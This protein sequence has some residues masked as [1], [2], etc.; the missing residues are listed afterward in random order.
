[1]WN[2]LTWLRVQIEFWD[3]MLT[4]IIDQIFDGLQNLPIC[5]ELFYVLSDTYSGNSYYDKWYFVLKTLQCS[6]PSFGGKNRF[7]IFFAERGHYYHFGHLSFIPV[8]PLTH[9][10]V[11]SS[12]TPRAC[13]TQLPIQNQKH[14]CFLQFSHLLDF[15]TLLISIFFT[16][17]PT[18]V[19]TNKIHYKQISAS[20]YFKYAA[21][22]NGYP[23]GMNVDNYS[24]PLSAILLIRIDIFIIKRLFCS[25][26]AHLSLVA[27]LFTVF[28]HTNM[29]F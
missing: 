17:K 10:Q 7:S 9:V 28:L 25:T 12:F 4:N 18:S 2:L 29:G 24:H 21:V 27:L 13:R 1:M 6:W 14:L 22:W 19:Y 16:P 23:T 11:P 3:V 20:K 26:H 5:Y 8:K 15:P